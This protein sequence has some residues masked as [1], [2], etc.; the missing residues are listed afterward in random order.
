MFVLL[1]VCGIYLLRTKLIVIAYWIINCMRVMFDEVTQLVS[2][3][4]VHNPVFKRLSGQ[5]L[6]NDIQYV[7]S[8]FKKYLSCAYL[9]LKDIMNLT[10]MRS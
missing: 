1:N 4:S 2:F 8:I 7:G 5:L 9:N 10:C 6:V 3:S